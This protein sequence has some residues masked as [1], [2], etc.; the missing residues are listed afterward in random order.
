MKDQVKLLYLLFIVLAA[1][2]NLS[3]IS[4]LFFT[5]DPGLYGSIAKTMIFKG[6]Y[7]SLYNCGTD[8]L[9]KPHFPF[10]MAALSF[11]LFGI[12]TWAYRLPALLFFAMGCVYTYLLSRKYYNLEVAL[13]AVLIL[14]TS[15]YILMGN[16]DVRAEPYLIGLITGAIYHISCLSEKFTIKDLLLA[17]VFT[18]CAIMT[19]G[20]FVVVPIGGSL[21]GQ[22]LFTRKIGS[23]FSIKWL[24]LI[25]LTIVFTLPELYALYVQFD[26]HPEKTVFN[27]HNVSGIKWFLWDSQFGRFANNGPISQQRSGDVFYYL[28]TLL[29]AFAP[30]CLMFFYSLY[31]RFSDVIRGRKMKEYYSLFGASLLLL[32]FS[33]SRFQLPFYTDIIF[34]LFAIIVAPYCV[35]ILS[36]R[37]R[38]FRTT[39]WWLYA[40]LLVLAILV[41]HYYSKPA[42]YLFLI[43]AL[44]V[45]GA[46]IY[47]VNTAS[48]NNTQKALL[49]ACAA[50]LFAN[51]YLNFNV[52][53][54]VSAYNGQNAAAKYLNQPQFDSYPVYSL[55]LVN[56]VLQFQYKKPLHYLSA[57][58]LKAFPSGKPM[59]CYASQWWVDHL[60]QQN[61]PFKILASFVDYP[62]EQILPAFINKATRPTVL[63]KVYVITK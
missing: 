39:S 24:G 43:I 55:S 17:A 40:V 60:R 8:W 34:P 53:P 18:A 62:Q 46:L 56:N 41:I 14:L 9:D 5:D 13:T 35:A 28:H 4:N 16:T 50:V 22:L 6:E 33:L 10:W 11:K 27:R 29:W 44:I 58:D 26:L 51:A 23:L 30:W 38:V 54:V 45:L 42:N 2:V 21:I 49:S 19:K 25:L 61:I 36:K 37:G 59:L 32:L 1:A 47:F 52:Y 20:I 57:A 15:Q 31:R 7:L 3:G 63:S 12:S 48:V